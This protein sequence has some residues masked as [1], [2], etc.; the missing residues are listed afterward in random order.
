MAGERSGRLDGALSAVESAYHYDQFDDPVSLAGFYGHAIAKGHCF[1][2][3]NKRT[4][5]QAM[6]TVLLEHGID[7]D[8]PQEAVADIIEAVASG[9]KSR[10]DLIDFLKQVAQEHTEDAKCHEKERT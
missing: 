1:A 5:L 8:L 2:D 7:T 10:D 3:G 9:A 6:Q 4:A